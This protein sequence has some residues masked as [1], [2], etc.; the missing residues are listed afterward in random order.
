MP[1]FG[2]AILVACGGESTS[3]PHYL[4]KG[5]VVSFHFRGCR[6]GDNEHFGLFPPAADGPPRAG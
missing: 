5:S 2:H 6:A 4:I 1:L 3:S